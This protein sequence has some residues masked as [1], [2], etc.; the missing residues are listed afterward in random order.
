ML[1]LEQKDLLIGCILGD[2]NVQ[3]NGIN[4]RVAFDHSISQLEYV[5]WKHLVLQPYTTP[6]VEY[7]VYDKR[8]HKNYKKVRFK[9]LTKPFFNDYY[10]IF[11]TNKVKTIPQN[12]H[13]YLKSELALAVWYLDDGALRTDCRGLRLHTNSFSFQ[14][15][16]LLKNVL[17][18]NFEID[19]QIHK[20]GKGFNIYIGTF[21]KQS[22]KFCDIIR[23]VVA[24]KI[25]SMLYKF[26]K[27]C[28]D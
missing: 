28:N 2:C 11:Y 3:Q 13:E 25:P 8:N 18:K 6:I 21:N 23:P 9:T 14:E 1:E 19:C 5:K 16:H 22:E 26:L 17:K 4:Y 15:V 10:Q 20:Q 7:S 24:S 12:I 27:P